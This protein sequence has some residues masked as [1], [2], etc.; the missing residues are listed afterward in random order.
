MSEHAWTETGPR[1]RVADDAAEAPSVNTADMI[2]ISGGTF[3]S[4]RRRT[5]ELFLRETGMTK[6]ADE[7]RTSFSIDQL[8]E[9]L[10]KSLEPAH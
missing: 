1:F 7:K 4:G 3:R 10:Q 5:L 9:K 8:V 6:K 2:R